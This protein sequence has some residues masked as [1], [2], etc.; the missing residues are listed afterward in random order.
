MFYKYLLIIFLCL[1][2]TCYATDYHFTWTPNTENNLE[3]YRLY[4][5]PFSGGPYTQVGEDIICGCGDFTC[6]KASDPGLDPVVVYFWV[7]RAYDESGR[8]TGS[9]NETSSTR[10][11]PWVAARRGSLEVRK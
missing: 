9:S 11:L 5:S 6:A 8:E 4:R 7:V 10:A 2:S 3:G 1:A